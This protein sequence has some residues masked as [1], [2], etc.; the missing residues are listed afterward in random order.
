METQSASRCPVARGQAT[1][2]AIVLLFVATSSTA[3]AQVSPEEHAAHHPEEA[4]ANAGGSGTR[5]MGGP[6]EGAGPKN[7]MGGMMGG[8]GGGMMGGGMMDGMMEKMGAPKPKDLYPSLMELPDL[9]M[10]R[11]HALEQE[12]HET[13]DRRNSLAG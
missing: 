4:G 7:G 10:E 3:I 13:N 9:P 1:F 8:K 11:R 12:A 2:T 5:G 6:P